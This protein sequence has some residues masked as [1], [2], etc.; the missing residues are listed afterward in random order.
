MHLSLISYFASSQLSRGEAKFHPQLSPTFHCSRKMFVK[1]R[2]DFEPNYSH[3]RRI[4]IRS[5]VED[6]KYKLFQY[7][8]LKTEVKA[9]SRQS[10]L[11]SRRRRS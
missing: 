10:S 4:L 3:A 1:F 5:P 2:Q 11:V 7:F 8:V 9:V 6:K